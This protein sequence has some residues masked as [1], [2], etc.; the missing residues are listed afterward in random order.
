VAKAALSTFS[1]APR[2]ITSSPSTA[3]FDT[4]A[5]GLAVTIE[6]VLV[7]VL[8]TPSSTC[9]ANRSWKS[10]YRAANAISRPPAS[11]SMFASVCSAR[12]TAIGTGVPSAMSRSK[13]PGTGTCRLINSAPCVTKSTARS[14]WNP[15]CSLISAGN[16]AAAARGA[17]TGAERGTETE[18]TMGAIIGRICAESAIGGWTGSA[19][20]G[21][22]TTKVH[23]DVAT[24]PAPTYL[25]TFMVT[26][27]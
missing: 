10:T 15:T 16:V 5:T 25:D 18:A 2:S 11:I 27:R 26:P 21:G 19:A 14:T 4:A 9:A 12:P 24:T 20:A 23:T 3:E 1:D 17:A 13:V 7:T 22:A 8:V 6:A